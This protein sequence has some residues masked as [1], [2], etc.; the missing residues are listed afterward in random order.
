MEDDKE[1]FIKGLTWLQDNIETQ[2]LEMNKNHGMAEAYAVNKLRVISRFK[3]WIG[4]DN[5]KIA[6]VTSIF[7]NINKQILRSI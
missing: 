2:D 6:E 4:H 5:P 1:L 7:K 3:L